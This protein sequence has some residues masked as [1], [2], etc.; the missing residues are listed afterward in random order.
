MAKEKPSIIPKIR[1]PTT[2][3]PNMALGPSTFSDCLVKVPNW[4]KIERNEA[5]TYVWLAKDHR[6]WSRLRSNS[7]G[8][9]F[10]ECK[11]ANSRQRKTCLPKRRSL[12]PLRWLFVWCFS[13][14]YWGVDWSRWAHCDIRLCR[15][16]WS[17]Q[18]SPWQR[19]LR[20]L[21]LFSRDLQ[22]IIKIKQSKKK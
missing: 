14:C 7:T 10:G 11:L 22:L 19:P 3:A 17:H 6:L 12:R 15:E 18:W 2:A 9:L 16:I 1:P 21:R 13:C 4:T 20:S 5:C 8:L